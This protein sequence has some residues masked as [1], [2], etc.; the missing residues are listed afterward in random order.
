MSD[1][2]KGKIYKLWSPSKN[3]VYY[4]S[5]IETLTQRL[6]K[7]KYDYK[8]YNED[9]TK[10]YT[11]SFLVLECE[12]YKIELLEEYACNNKQ[13]LLKKES[14]YIKINEC[15]NKFIP[16]RTNKEYQQDNKEKISIA[17]K[18]YYENNKKIINEVNKLYYY[19][20]KEKNLA[21]MKIYYEGHKE[22]CKKLSKNYYETKKQ[23]NLIY[24]WLLMT[25]IIV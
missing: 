3:L 13:Q 7:H 2:Q 16:D 18:I 11:T 10:K 6:S 9:N 23:N 20:N 19:N 17:R 24:K 1:Y 5:T 8:K 4:G 12:D 14:E 22:Y 15:V 25:G 21:A